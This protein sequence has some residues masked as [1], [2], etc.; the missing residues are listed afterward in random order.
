MSKKIFIVGPVQMYPK[1]LE[2]RQEDFP[3]FRTEIF[4]SVMF[5]N[6]KGLA[7]L[8]GNSKPNNLLFF[9]MSGTGAMEATVENCVTSGDRALVINGGTFGRRFCELLKW[10]NISF[11]SVDLKWNEELTFE[12]L[13]PFENRGYTTLFVNLHETSTGQLYDIKMLSDFAKRNSMIL[14]VDAI[15]TFLADDYDM[16]KYGID[17]TIIS[18]Q[19][20]LCCSAGM[21]VVALSDKMKEKINK[22]SSSYFNFNDYIKNMERGQ[23]PYT[24]A[25]GVAYEIQSM[26]N[27]I[28]ETGKDVWLNVIKEKA[29]YFRKKAKDLGLTIPDT[30]PLSNMLTPVYFEDIDANKIVNMLRDKYDIYINPCGGELGSRMFRVSHIGNTSK[31]DIDY[32]LE[33]LIISIREIKE[34]SLVK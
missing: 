31:E 29:L 15:S 33:K 3:Y 2:L 1:T 23:T 9:T 20:G 14:I 28:N 30:Y 7:E 24:P 25:V 34:Q 10:H 12:H 6:A 8:L 27:L 22:P 26:V 5:D 19:K 21:S 32:L 18:S 13:K 17:A 16:E 4:S 11:D